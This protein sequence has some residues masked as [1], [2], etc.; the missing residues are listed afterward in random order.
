[1]VGRI[2]K[3]YARGTSWSV[4]IKEDGDIR[5]VKT[6]KENRQGTPVEKGVKRGLFGEAVV[7]RKL[8]GIVQGRRVR[9][10]IGSERCM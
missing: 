5:T 7:G 3:E 2:G 1:M 8:G 6:K 4:K 9:R 10:S